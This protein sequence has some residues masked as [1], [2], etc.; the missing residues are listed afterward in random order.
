MK[1]ENRTFIVSGGSSGLGAAT[2]QDLLARNAYVSILDR[3]P[4]PEELKSSS[5]V[6][7]F[8]VDI[9]EVDQINKG[10]EGT[11]E[12]TKETSAPLGGVVNC[13][14]VAVA[15]KIIDSHN[16]PHSLDLW[17]FAIA[18]NLTGTFNLTRLALK[19]LVKV[20][21]EEGPDGE[22]GVIIFVASAAAYEGQ[23]GQ[24]AYAATKGGIRSMTLP[25]AR[26]LARHGVRVV[27]IAPGVFDSSMTANFSPKARK[28]LE[29]EGI[30]YPRR[31]GQ[32]Y[33]FAGT[34]RWIL[35]TPYINGE[36]IRLSGAGRLPGK[37]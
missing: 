16:E 7:Y 25:M 10:V 37:L 24:T 13:A 17:D 9:R 1:V 14:G 35:D 22:R 34:V 12:W 26:D 23:P 28:S 2:V 27:T 20:A 30:I 29:N 32:P 15:A 11:V 8:A 21:P 6:R 3:S 4:P 33:E 19:H 18:V 36:T 5:R 31:F